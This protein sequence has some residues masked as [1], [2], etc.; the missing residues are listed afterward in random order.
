LWKEGNSKE[1]IDVCFGDS[2]I[3][4]EALRCIQVGL[5]CVQ[6]H[7]NDIPNMTYVFAML[8][9]ETILAQPNEPGFLI[10]RL[11]T[12]EEFTTKSSC[13]I[14]DVTITLLDVR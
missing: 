8:T 13:S 7:P 5:L 3:L 11:S 14:N 1:L 12:D 6:H 9:N 10:K 2:Y 4:S